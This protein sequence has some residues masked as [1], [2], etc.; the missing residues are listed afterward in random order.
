M[1]HLSIAFLVCMMNHR[2]RFG[3]VF[4]SKIVLNVEDLRAQVNAKPRLSS[5]RCRHI[6]TEFIMGSIE[7]I[8]FPY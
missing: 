7:S 5:K 3:D 2:E 4:G 1:I 6:L 8:Q